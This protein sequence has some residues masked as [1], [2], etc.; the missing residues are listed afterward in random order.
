M[1][2]KKPLKRHTQWIGD[3]QIMFR[4]SVFLFVAIS[5]SQF[6]YA[7]DLDDISA[8][9]GVVVGDAYVDLAMGVNEDKFDDTYNYAVGLQLA[10]LKSVG[11]GGDESLISDQMFASNLDKMTNIANSGTYTSDVLIEVINCYRIL[12]PMSEKYSDE[13]RETKTM[14]NQLAPQK[15]SFMRRML[16]AGG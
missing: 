5:L 9:A 6:V 8:C 15:I 1:T 2:R 10:A 16:R 4:Q 3:H 11:L 13:L 14:L 7:S 12:A